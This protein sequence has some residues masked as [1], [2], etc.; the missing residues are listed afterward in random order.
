MKGLYFWLYLL[1]ILFTGSCT[2]VRKTW[3][4]YSIYLQS[5]QQSKTVIVLRW[6]QASGTLTSQTN[7]KSAHKTFIQLI[8][9][10]KSEKFVLT[11]Q[12]YSACRC[13]RWH[14][15][16]STWSPFPAGRAGYLS[17]GLAWVLCAPCW[18][19]E[20]SF[21]PIRNRDFT[22]LPSQSI[23]HFIFFPPLSTYSAASLPVSV[24]A[25]IWG[26]K[27]KQSDACVLPGKLTCTWMLKWN[28]GTQK[29]KYKL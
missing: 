27:L 8:L 10:K 19:I 15:P 12:N 6:Q 14:F 4:V 26:R 5:Q 22:V 3:S 9:G 20:V 17:P 29:S 13:W 21:S 25:S 1:V 7:R 23:F 18:R 28:S 16:G 11:T 2:E 24:F